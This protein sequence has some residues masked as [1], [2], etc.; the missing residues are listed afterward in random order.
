MKK[1]EFSAF[2]AE[3]EVR[4]RCE[5]HYACRF[6]K[7][8]HSPQLFSKNMFLLLERLNEKESLRVVLIL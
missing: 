6:L 4:V 5:S 1:T 3:K 8:F 7:A 2:I